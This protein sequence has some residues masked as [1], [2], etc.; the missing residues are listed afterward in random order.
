MARKD[1]PMA[2]CL[3][4]HSVRIIVLSLCLL[5]T[6]SNAH[7][8]DHTATT[9]RPFTFVELNCENLFD[10]SHDT[11]KQDTEWLDDSPRH[12]TYKRYRQ[13]LN[14]IGK[15]IIACGE[16]GDGWRLPDIVALCEVENDSVMRDLTK[17]SLLRNSRYEYVMTESP[18]VR[19]IDVALMFSP[20]SFHIISHRSIRVTTLKDMR[21]T[22]DIL[23]AN[24]VIINGDTLHVFV[25]H[26]PSRYGGERATRPYR[27]Q[28]AATLAAAIDSIY[29]ISPE[30]PILVAGDF[31][32]YHDDPAPRSL[33]Q[34]GLNN[35][36]AQAKGCNGAQGTYKFMGEWRSIDH[37]MASPK[38]TERLMEAHIAD[39]KFLLEEDEKYG[40]KMPLRTYH[41]FK[42]K[43]GY[44]DHL[45]LVA[46]FNLEVPE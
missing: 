6:I 21:P 33:Y 5:L 27:M 18:D 41:G 34:H 16:S 13:K 24:G 35:I 14:N 37:I 11:L 20:S 36:T 42:Y 40:G 29:S 43:G 32:D 17:R 23:Y 4:A 39:L 3:N 44:S 8:Q 1:I 7:C 31:N 38:M 26:A 2:D 15:E 12:W 9:T 19:G 30:T 46:R 25:V 28:V 22:R 45:P 10:N